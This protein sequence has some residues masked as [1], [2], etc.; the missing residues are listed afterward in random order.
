MD[1]PNRLIDMHELA[2][3]LNVSVDLV[4]QHVKQ[5]RIPIT[6]PLGSRLVKFTPDQVAQIIADGAV[7]AQA[8]PK[9]AAPIAITTARGARRRRTA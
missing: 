8:A 2:E 7:P 9:P 6:Q 3:I 5:R 1:L 4:R